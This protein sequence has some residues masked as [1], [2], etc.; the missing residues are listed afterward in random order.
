MDKVR[1]GENAG[2]VW[3]KL[4]SKGSLTIEELKK[5]TGLELAEVLTAIGWLARE[6]KIIFSKENSITSISLYHENYY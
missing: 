1:I 3:R 2:I 5:E 4:E 6:D